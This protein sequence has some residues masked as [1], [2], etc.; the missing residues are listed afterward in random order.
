[1]LIILVGK[2]VENEQRG[3]TPTTAVPAPAGFVLAQFTV[4]GLIAQ[5]R[6]NGEL[7]THLA[8]FYFDT[9]AVLRVD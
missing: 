6:S 1:M 7:L 8:R 4:G 9:S 5:K 3:F 2:T